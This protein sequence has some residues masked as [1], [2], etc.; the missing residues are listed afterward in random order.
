MKQLN[1]LDK[2][3]ILYSKNHYKRIDDPLVDLG[4]I[5]N[6]ACAL[7]EGYTPEYKAYEILCETFVKVADDWMLKEFFKR[8]FMEFGTM[9]LREADYKYASSLMMG[10]LQCLKVRDDERVLWDIGEA[11]SKVWPLK[12]H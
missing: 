10:N 2:H 5:V 12:E 8:L 3:F 11:D 1:H 9:T 4:N 7:P 6:K